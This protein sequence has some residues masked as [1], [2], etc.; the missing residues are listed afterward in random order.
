MS[1]GGSVRKQ[2]ATPF[3]VPKWKSTMNGPTG[4]FTR[5]K[6]AKPVKRTEFEG[7]RSVAGLALS[8]GAGTDQQLR[9]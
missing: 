1:F 3:D 6:L 4:R 8:H 2:S 5:N 9:R 7:R